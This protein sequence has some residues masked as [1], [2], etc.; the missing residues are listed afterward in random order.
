MK[1]AEEE[2]LTILMPP[3][4]LKSARDL[5]IKH[6][7]TDE[8]GK[9]EFNTPQGEKRGTPE[10]WVDMHVDPSQFPHEAIHMLQQEK[11][12]E[13]FD[14]LPFIDLPDEWSDATDEQKEIYYSRPPE[15]MAF[16]YDYAASVT[17]PDGAPDEIYEDYEKIGGEVFETF[18]KYVEAY[19]KKL[20]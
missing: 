19:K 8:D 16:A 14:G 17:T 10:E 2:P 15:I 3:T 6:T 1:E 5:I 7:E 18:K 12:P 9:F 20:G 11:M 4:D 13:L